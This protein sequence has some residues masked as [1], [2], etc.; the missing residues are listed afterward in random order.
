MYNH[1]SSTMSEDI[2]QD[3]LDILTKLEPSDQGE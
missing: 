2:P 1:Q 3:V